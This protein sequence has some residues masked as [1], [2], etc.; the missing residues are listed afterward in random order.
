VY[1][2]YCFFVKQNLLLKFLTLKQL[3]GLLVRQGHVA[4]GSA[5]QKKFFKLKYF[6]GELSYGAKIQ[7]NAYIKNYI[8]LRSL[9]ILC[10]YSWVQE[11]ILYFATL[12]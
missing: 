4:D 3:K 12:L 5:G 6:S 8:E 11:A 9:Q 7:R 2:V 10:A 1:Q